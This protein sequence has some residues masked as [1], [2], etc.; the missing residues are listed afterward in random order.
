M[1]DQ[2]LIRQQALRNRRAMDQKPPLDPIDRIR[3]RLIEEAM[4]ARD[5]AASYAECRVKAS[6]EPA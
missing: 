1:V 2:R 3:Q 5:M 4:K 6:A